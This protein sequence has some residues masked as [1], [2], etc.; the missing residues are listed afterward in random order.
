MAENRA[1]TPN[2]RPAPPK[3]PPAPSV[4]PDLE[5]IAAATRPWWAEAPD[6]AA[7]CLA[8][9]FAPLRFAAIAAEAA[10]SL[11]FVAVFGAAALWWAGYIPDAVVAAY[12]GQLGDRALAIL[13]ASGVL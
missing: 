6:V 11:A 13:Q 2:P 9:A 1:P 5:R 7:K 8:L 10:V 4:R 3:R 12:L